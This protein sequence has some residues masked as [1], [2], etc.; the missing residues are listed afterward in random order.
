MKRLLL[1]FGMLLLGM[2]FVSANGNHAS[3]LGEGKQLVESGISCDNLSDGQLEAIGEYYMEQMH[4]GK[5]HEAMNNTMVQMVGEEGE[6]QM[7]VNMARMMYC[8]ENAMMDNGMMGSG[9]TMGMMPMMMNMM[10]SSGMMGSG[11]MMDSGMMGGQNPTQTSMAQGTSSGTM[12][13]MMGNNVFGSG[14]P[15]WNYSYWST[16][17]I[18]YSIFLVGLIVL[19]FFGVFKLARDLN[20]KDVSK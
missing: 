20:K 16:W 12:Q 18:F 2:V 5:Q 15:F 8:G 19:V 13:S 1:V 9:G 11:G 6:E 17:N 14:M 10:G 7:H 4:P 3:E